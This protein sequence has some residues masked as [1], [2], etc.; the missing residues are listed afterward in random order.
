MRNQFIDAIQEICRRRSKGSSHIHWWFAQTRIV[1][2]RLD[3]FAHEYGA[4]SR[5]PSDGDTVPEDYDLAH[6][7]LG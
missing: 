2:R 6:A 4:P 3:S 5:A 7:N 1:P